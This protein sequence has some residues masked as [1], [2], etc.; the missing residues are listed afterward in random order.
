MPLRPIEFHILVSLAS[1]DRHGYGI[2][3]EAARLSG[4]QAH[5]EPGTLYRALFRL[6]RDGWIAEVGRRLPST[7]EADRAPARQPRPPGKGT[8]SDYDER[9]RY[10]RLTAAGRRVAAAEAER[11]SRLVREARAG[12]LLTRA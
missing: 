1:E 3:Q 9:R 11:L 4:G 7:G 8:R 6:L 12:G 10:Y 5:I 2:M